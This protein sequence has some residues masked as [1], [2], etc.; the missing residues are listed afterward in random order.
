MVARAQ[1]GAGCRVTLSPQLYDAVIFDMDGVI[2]QTARV[3]A[4]AWKTLFDEFLARYAREHHQPMRQFDMETDYREYVDGKKR[5]DGLRSFLESRGI[6]LPLGNSDDPPD[7]ETLYGLGRRKN[8]LFLTLLQ[9]KGVEI[10]PSTVE[11]IRILRENDLRTAVIT[12]SRNGEA[13]LKAAGITHLF[14]AFVNGV[15]TERL[16]L[17]GKPAPDVFLEAARRLNALPGRTIVIEDAIAGVEAGKAG[18]FGLIIGVNRANQARR[19]KA[20][21]ADVVVNDLS[22]VSLLQEEDGCTAH[23]NLRDAEINDWI[24]TYNKYLPEEQGRRETLCALGNG[25]FVTRGAACSSRDDGIH[26]PGTYFAGVYNRLASR[27]TGDGIEKVIVN[28]DLVNFP[29]WLVLRF[30]F[31]D[32]DWFD[33]DQAELL[34][35]QQSVNLK[36]GVFYLEIDFRDQNGY[37]GRLR[38][39]RLVSMYD[40]HYAGLELTVIP[41]DKVDSITVHSGLDGSVINNNVKRYEKFQKKHLKILEACQPDDETIFLKVATNQSHTAVAQAART[42]LFLEDESIVPKRVVNNQDEAIAQEM[43]VRLAEGQALRIEKVI[44]AFTSRDYAISECGPAVCQWIQDAPDFERLKENQILTWKHLWHRF[45]INME[46]SVSGLAKRASLILRL[47]VFQILQALSHFSIDRDIGVPAR[48]WHGEAY[49]GHVF[50][51]DILVFRY[52]N[53]R[54]PELTASLIKYRYRRLDEARKLARQSGF[55]G[56]MF[57]WQSGSNGEEE[58]PPVYVNPLTNQWEPDFTHLQRHVNSAIVYNIWQYYEVSGNIEFMFEYGAEIILEI[59]RFWAS[60]AQYNPDLDR[61]EIDGVVGPDEYHDHFPVDNPLPGLK[62]NAYTNVMAVWVLCRALQLFEIMPQDYRS[63]LVDRLNLQTEEL[64]RWDQISRKMRVVFLKEGVIGQFEGYETLQDL[65]LELLKDFTALNNLDDILRARQDTPNRYKISKQADVLMLFYL[66][67]W[68]EL[69][70]LFNRLGYPFSPQTILK[71]I[72]YYEPRTTHGSTLSRIIY[73]WVHS[74]T[75]RRRSLEFLLEA[76]E[77]DLSDIQGGTTR[78][79]IHLGAM[80][81]TLDIVQRCYTGIVMKS[82]VL[83]FNPRLPDQITVIEFTMHYRFHCLEIRL[84]Q[85]KLTINALPGAASPVKIGFNQKVRILKAGQKVVFMM[86]E[87]GKRKRNDRQ[88]ASINPKSRPKPES[89]IY[90]N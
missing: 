87:K 33:L 42:R 26:Y 81:G 61:Y 59:A 50:W 75:N 9:Q 40:S 27:I 32:G 5:E 88:K 55:Q 56:A 39:R 2:T 71:T 90:P 54:F 20:Q 46:T 73:S 85:E 78:E 65:P 36:E 45:D 7:A 74:R 52:L 53:L 31:N 6:A 12:A 21:G 8:E 23:S 1:D 19:L 67:D 82:D 41:L 22:Q 79:G 68:H 47:H 11:F 17:P 29:N 44:S 48:G 66:F 57:P 58:T 16:N 25:Y 15:E 64:Q 38:E 60:M 18:G 4:E 63:A 28:E 14:D 43:T 24:F 83:W 35:F 13:I 86:T 72:D 77:S 34:F 49:Q 76:F 30:R 84:T 89:I 3:H 70:H 51:D 62:N 37:R 10:Y 69:K 80:A